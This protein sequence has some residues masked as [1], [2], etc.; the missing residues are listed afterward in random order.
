MRQHGTIKACVYMPAEL[1]VFM[2]QSG[3]GN[4]EIELYLM[5]LR[6]RRLM[7]KPWQWPEQLQWQQPASSMHHLVLHTQLAAMQ[8]FK[9]AVGSL[10]Y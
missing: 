1:Y 5:S 9:K 4:K 7:H 8:S 6:N 3:C 2:P 10:A